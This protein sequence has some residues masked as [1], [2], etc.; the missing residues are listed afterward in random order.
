MLRN[1]AGVVATP[2]NDAATTNIDYGSNRGKSTIIAA[3]NRMPVLMQRIVSSMRSISLRK[4]FPPFTQLCELKNH[5]LMRTVQT[6]NVMQSLQSI[7][8]Y[9]VNHLCKFARVCKL[10]IEKQSLRTD[11]S[12]RFRQPGIGSARLDLYLLSL[13]DVS[14]SPRSMC[15]Y[16]VRGRRA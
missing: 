13:S 8:L 5:S 6:V 9:T 1:R 2:M 14:F 7:Q 4:L 12:V 10:R 16:A 11:Y 3:T 15:E